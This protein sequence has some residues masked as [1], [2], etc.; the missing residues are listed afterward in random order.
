MALDPRWQGPLTN[1]GIGLVAL[2]LAALVVGTAEDEAEAAALRA[3]PALDARG[4]AAMAAGAPVL[5]EG[6]VA[7]GPSAGEAGLVLAQRQ[8]AVGVTKPGTN[9]M[10]FAWEPVP[11]ASAADAALRIDSASGPVTL[12]N[13]DF[14]WRDPPR[15]HGQAATVVAGSTRTVGFAAGDPITVRAAVVD[16]G[17]ARVRALEVFGGT[18]A[19]YL[20]ALAA[21]DA[22]PLVLGGGFALLG[23]GMLVAAALGARRVQRA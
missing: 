18:R 20:D 23:A 10:R 14:A 3:L 22:V 17:Q 7:S 12:V 19:A 15:V 6:R 11:P 5:I 8:Q 9:E 13:T 16:G 1:A 21:S 4:L 2:L